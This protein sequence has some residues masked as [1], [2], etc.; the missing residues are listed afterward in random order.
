MNAS[1]VIT[2]AGTLIGDSDAKEIDEKNEEVVKR[3]ISALNIAVDTISTKYYSLIKRMDL[4]SDGEAKIS[5]DALDGRLFEVVS[6]TN[7]RG[8]E[9]EYFS[10]PFCLYLPE[11]YR[12]YEVKYKYLPEKV[13]SLDSDLPVLPFVSKETIGYLLASDL[14]LSRGMF[15]ESKFWF[16]AFENSINRALSSRR[17]RTVLNK[18]LI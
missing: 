17:A 14:C 8:Q 7:K 15:E 18:K 1:E 16:N 4:V 10:L 6:V 12:S 13:T 2:I 3:Y 9:V 11:A 5:Y